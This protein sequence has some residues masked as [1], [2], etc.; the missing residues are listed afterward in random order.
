LRYEAALFD[1]GSTLIEYEN[2][3]W[4]TLGR[5]GLMNAYPFLRQVLPDIPEPVEFG[6]RFRDA[7]GQVLDERAD[8]TEKDVYAICTEV[9]RRMG[10]NLE[11]N[12]IEKFIDYYYQPVTEQIS[13][14]P[15]ALEVVAD[16]KQDGLVLG[17]ISNS[18]FPEKFHRAEMERFGLLKHFDFTI[19]SCTVGIRKP[20]PRIF[21]MAL[22]L[23]RVE[24]SRAFFVGDRPD[25]DIVGARGAGIS[26]VL[27]ERGRENPTNIEPDY[28][29]KNLMELGSI[30]LK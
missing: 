12:K 3:D 17:L 28:R 1:L 13:L 23:A 14:I 2:H 15:G 5:M 9:F 10:W 27:K 19:F 26:T 21:E 11:N 25:V 4:D 16:L 8:Y 22:R 20:S 7:Y 29:I 30:V 6:P 18:V 24:P